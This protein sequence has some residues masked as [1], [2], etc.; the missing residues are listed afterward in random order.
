MQRGG[1]RRVAGGTFVSRIASLRLIAAA[2]AAVSLA[3]TA[4]AADNLAVAGRSTTV[5]IVGTQGRIRWSTDSGL[6][7][8]PATGGPGSSVAL[9]AVVDWGQVFVAVGDAGAITFSNS[10]GSSWSTASSPTVETLRAVEKIGSN[11]VAAGDGGTIVHTFNLTGSAGWE[12]VSVAAGLTADLYDVGP[13]ASHSY[14][15]GAGGTIVQGN[16][17]GTAFPTVISGVPTTAD[18]RAY[19][20]YQGNTLLAVGDGGVI[21]RSTNDGA[22]WSQV[23]SPTGEDLY[24]LAVYNSA[25]AVAAGKNGVLLWSNDGSAWEVSDASPLRDDLY[26]ARFTAGYFFLVGAKDLVARALPTAVGTGEGWAYTSVR[27][28]TWGSLKGAFAGPR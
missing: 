10:T 16:T 20:Q 14:A 2:A 1:R 27:P 12:G 24:A 3:A 26:G 17:L 23:V 22:N 11:L 15:V 4:D 7:S 21:L 19:A 8:A 28:T 18:L 25:I 6:T 9:R 5:I 13:S